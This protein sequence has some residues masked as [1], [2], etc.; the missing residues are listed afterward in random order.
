M[1]KQFT[2]TLLACLFL[3][4]TAATL[5]AAE[6]AKA[7]KALDVLNTAL[8][9]W[10]E[11][12]QPPEGQPARTFVTRVRVVKA[13]GLPN[14]VAGLSAELAYQAPDRLR[15][16]ADVNGK[17]YSLG[18]SG[19]ELWVDIPHKQFALLAKPGLPRFKTHP[20]EIDTTQLP[21]FSCPVTPAVA[22]FAV[23]AKARVSLEGEQGSAGT[24][25]LRL[26]PVDARDAFDVRL[27][28]RESDSLPVRIA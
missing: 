25:T 1:P 19:Q 5:R 8:A 4:G 12:V 11:V 2:A 27:T 18:R 14:A 17:A 20:D 28:L 9:R 21:E 7:P 10:S 24:R 6:P 26:T 13:E 16:D 3:I 15:V 22:G 23:T